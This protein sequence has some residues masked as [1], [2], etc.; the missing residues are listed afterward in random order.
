MSKE[1]RKAI[2]EVLGDAGR[3]R[4]E[5]AALRK[6]AGVT[7]T[8]ADRR[9][10]AALTPAQRKQVAREAGEL[11]AKMLKDA[12][13]GANT[14]KT[15]HFGDKGGSV[16]AEGVETDAVGYL[17]GSWAAQRQQNT[18]RLLGEHLDPDPPRPYEPPDTIGKPITFL[19]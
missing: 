18:G 3:Q 12:E 10:L 2:A 4:K 1:E 14:G 7:L 5:S 11:A 9:Q 8:E 6:F 19:H 13:E 17:L 16:V 15:W